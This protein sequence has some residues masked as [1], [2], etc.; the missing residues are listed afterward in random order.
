MTTRYLPITEWNRLA[1]ICKE[2]NWALPHPLSSRAIVAEVDGQIVG[3]LFMQSLLQ[4]EPA[5]VDKKHKAFPFFKMVQFAIETNPNVHQVLAHTSQPRVGKLMQLL[6][7]V[8]QIGTKVY[9]WVRPSKE[10]S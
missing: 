9:T 10:T 7:M 3:V 4:I 2:Q 8:E 1:P 5:W 6:G